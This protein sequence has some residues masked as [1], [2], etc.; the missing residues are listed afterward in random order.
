[1]TK[2]CDYCHTTA[3][4]ETHVCAKCGANSFHRTEPPYW[5]GWDENI[6]YNPEKCGLRIISVFDEPGL[7]YEYDTTLVLQDICSGK[8]YTVRDSGCSCP[9]PFEN[10]HNFSDMQEISEW[11]ALHF[12]DPY[13]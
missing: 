10:I 12:K 8:F 7:S 5:G 2:T 1:M 11:A 3:D 13:M 4:F 9:T 6:Y